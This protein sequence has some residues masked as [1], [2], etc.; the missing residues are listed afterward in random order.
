MLPSRATTP[1][2]IFVPPR[3][4]PIAWLACTAGT[5]TPRMAASGEKPYRVYRGGRTKGKV[6]LARHER[7]ARRAVRSDGPGPGK[8]VERPPRRRRL[9]LGRTWRRWTIRT[10]LGP[11]VLSAIWG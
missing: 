4:T 5:V 1:A 7:A 3:S 2:R 10:L 9:W 8:I 11:L 6:P